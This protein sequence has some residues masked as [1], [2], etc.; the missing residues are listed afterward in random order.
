[1]ASV[2]QLK[3]GV[4]I[5]FML[6][7]FEGALRKW[8]LP[9][10]SNPLLLVR[11]PVALWLLVSTW[12]KGLLP[13]NWYLSTIFVTGIAGI[14]TATFF[15]HGNLFVA[16]YGARILLIHFPLIFVIG[17]VFSRD[18]VLAI[19]RITVLISIPMAILIALQFYSPQSA[20][21]NRGVG[22]NIEGGGF[23]GGALGFFRPPGTFSFT[24]GNANFF[25]FAAPF[26]FYFWFY[27]A[28]INRLILIAATL[29]LFMA[30]PLSISRTLLFQVIISGLFM[31]IATLQRPNAIGKLVSSILVLITASIILS[32]F[33]F[34]RTATEVFTLRFDGAQETEGGVQGVIGDRYI[35]GLLAGLIGSA[36]KPFF[37]YGL[38]IGSSVGSAL[39]TGATSRVFSEEDW[40]RNIGELGPLMGL[41]VIIVRVSLS[42]KIAL[43]SYWKLRLGNMLPWMLLSFGLLI[44]PQGEWAQPTSLGFSTLIAGLLIASLREAKQDMHSAQTS[45]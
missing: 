11:D 23:N 14:F 17:R 45:E 12:R 29:G 37:G 1:M 10:L 38:G 16:L 4:W 21:V 26:I 19:G 43:A 42:I 39:L 22:G 31:V 35:G 25:S 13:A 3:I 9:G 36:D 28:Y 18:D 6:L 15:G 20:W 5:Y 7:I 34:F 30:I 33:A 8:V 32:Q 44:I 2:K 24:S 40:G 27:P 41:L